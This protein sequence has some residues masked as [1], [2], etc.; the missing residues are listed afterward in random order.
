MTFVLSALIASPP[1]DR[2][3]RYVTK[4]FAPE[5]DLRV[6][7]GGIEHQGQV[8]ACVSNSVVS[9]CEIILDRA[10]QFIDL[11]RQF[12]YDVGRAWEARRGEPGMYLRNGMKV[13]HQ[14]GIPPEA[15]YAYRGDDTTLDPPD[16]IIALAGQRKITRYESIDMGG[17]DWE[18]Q[19]NAIRSALTEGCPVVFAMRIGALFPAI[20]GPLDVHNYPALES[21]TPGNGYIG[22]HA[23]VIV[24][25]D[26]D[27]IIVENS[28]GLG[29]GDRG[30]AQLGIPC[31][32]DIFEAWAVR[33]FAGIDPTTKAAHDWAMANQDAVR[34]FALA[35]YPDTMQVLVDALIAFGI[36]AP[37]F[38]GIFSWP[39]ETVLGY[40]RND[41][42]GKTLDW[43][44]FKWG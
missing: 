19:F 12:A 24:G 2:D 31:F 34:A 6:W 44:D 22:N 25:H 4:A 5:S 1:D 35:Q 29:F 20:F 32:V 33:G 18:P 9:A 3:F 28:W 10:G 37:E 27:R 42:V 39:T 30:Y 8:S 11:S 23:M 43:R 17:R 15:E 40:S 13:G 7:A 16:A 41:A 38:E 14:L 26:S 36:S 21:N